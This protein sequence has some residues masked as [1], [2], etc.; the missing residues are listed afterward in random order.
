M[1]VCAAL[2]PVGTLT[3]AEHVQLKFFEDSVYAHNYPD[4]YAARHPE[5]RAEAQQDASV[6]A[7]EDV[8]PYCK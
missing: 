3:S 6:K 8:S 2:K 4:E 1:G 7:A 5:L